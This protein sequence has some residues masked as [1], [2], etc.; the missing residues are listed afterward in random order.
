MAAMWVWR[1]VEYAGN[2]AS[3]LGAWAAVAALI[4]WAR[5]NS[6]TQVPPTG[7]QLDAAE[8]ALGRA[9]EH[10]WA[11]EVALRQLEDPRPLEVRWNDTPRGLSDHPALI[12]EG[13]VCGTDDAS[14][15]AA[16]FRRLPRRRLAILG[17]AGSGKTTLAVLLVLVLLRTRQPGE[18]VPVILSLSSDVLEHSH[19]RTWLLQKIVSE[20]P[21]LRD[22]GAYGPD[23]VGELLASRR[24]LPVLDGLDGLDEIP[25]RFQARVFSMLNE[26]LGDGSPLVL[27]CRT[28]AYEQAVAECRDVLNGTA[29]IEPE[30]VTSGSAADFLMLAA[31][32]GDL[33]PGWRTLARRLRAEP[34]SPV[35]LALQS[36]L[37][38][39]LRGPRPT[40]CSPQGFP[41]APASR[42][43]VGCNRGRACAHG[44][45]GV[46][47][48]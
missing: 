4:V 29:V 5:Q 15:A 37:N 1:G 16:A 24:V 48:I 25:S 3:V 33:Q 30:P 39:S 45:A 44:R 11:R 20:Y 26:A 10:V 21:A 17:P 19:L 46:C 7:E 9:V 12:G 35:A 41:G 36:P 13:L 34:R 22:T 43:A 18:P 23:A 31:A 32:P 40:N 14:G 28:A 2:A 6:G 8:H 38:V 27:T 42:S 47:P